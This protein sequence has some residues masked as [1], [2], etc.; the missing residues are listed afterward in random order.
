MPGVEVNDGADEQAGHNPDYALEPYGWLCQ[1]QPGCPA[2]LIMSDNHELTAKINGS[3]TLFSFNE[4][5]FV[6]GSLCLSKFCSI[7]PKILNLSTAKPKHTTSL[8]NVVWAQCTENTLELDFAVRKG[9]DSP[10]QLIHESAQV[11]DEVTAVEWTEKLMAAAYKGMCYNLALLFLL[12]TLSRCKTTTQSEST[13]QPSGGA[14]KG[15]H[16][17]HS[18]CRADLESCK[19]YY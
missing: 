12:I 8:Y 14:G 9:E 19:V 17:L 13:R 1:L 18:N 15:S 2:G 10:L 7:Y 6:V 4:S 11:D 5:S 16:N 3:P